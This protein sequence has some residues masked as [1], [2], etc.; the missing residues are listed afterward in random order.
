MTDLIVK[1]VLTLPGVVDPST[2]YIV[3]AADATH[4]ELYFTSQDGIETR[5]VITESEVASMIAAAGGGGGSSGPIA[6]ANAVTRYEAL[7]SVGLK[8]HCLSSSTQWSGLSWTRATTTLTISH[9]AHGRAVGDRVIIKDTNVLVQNQLVTFVT[10]DTYDVACDDTGP[11]SGSNG[12]YTC[13]FKY[14]H[15]SEVPGAVT[16]GTLSVPANADIQLLSMRIHVKANSRPSTIYDV[17]V[18]VNA[19]SPV[20]ADTSNDTVYIP[21]VSIRSDADNLTVVGNT[22]ALNS[23]GSYAT[24]RL[25][26][27]GAVTQGQL[28]ALQF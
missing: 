10:T 20:G 15:N 16:G 27:L 25:G 21:I 2:L 9:P 12:K 22:I 17:T 14:A 5:K 13:G 18:P 3:K 11:T 23:S 24:F 28:M 8:C 7:S 4:V 6:I 1:R 26:A 19:Y